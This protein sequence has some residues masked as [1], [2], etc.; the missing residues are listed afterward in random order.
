MADDYRQLITDKVIGDPTFIRA[1]FSGQRRGEY[2]PWLKVELRPGHIKDQEHLQ[3]SYFES[4][5]SITK[6]YTG[7]EAAQKLEQSNATPPEMLTLS[8]SMSSSKSFGR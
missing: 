3:I 8:R 5:K 2:L 7:A 1:R 6:N 4:N